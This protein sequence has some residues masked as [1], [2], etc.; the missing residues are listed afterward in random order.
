[1]GNRFSERMPQDTFS[2]PGVVAT[3]QKFSR[4]VSIGSGV[5]YACVYASCISIATKE[6][7]L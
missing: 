5:P 2:I 4:L 1:M 7:T 6:V 3:V